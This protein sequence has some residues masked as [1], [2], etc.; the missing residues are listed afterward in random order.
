MRE[1][2][3]QVWGTGVLSGPA[4]ACVGDLRWSGPRTLSFP[5]QPPAHFCAPTHSRSSLWQHGDFCWPSPTSLRLLFPRK[6]GAQRS[7]WVFVSSPCGGCSPFQACT[8]RLLSQDPSPPP[9]PSVCCAIAMVTCGG[10]QPEACEWV[11]VPMS[12]GHEWHILTLLPSGPIALD[13]D[14][15]LKSSYPACRSVFPRSRVSWCLHV[16]SFLGAFH[17]VAGELVAA[18]YI[19]SGNQK[20]P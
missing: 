17:S 10:A 20:F 2:R 19:H 13:G 7:G 18:L 8:T 16:T 14:F 9:P 5:P 4:V 12:V 1:A 3:P 15:S 11:R 6:H